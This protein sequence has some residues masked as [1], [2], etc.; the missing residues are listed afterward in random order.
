MKNNYELKKRIHLM[1]EIRGFDVLLMVAFHWF[2][3]LGYLLEVPLGVTLFNFFRPAEP[4]FAGLFIVICGISCHLSRSNLKRGLLLAG[5]AVGLSAVMY[6]FMPEQMIWFG[7]LHF[8]ALAILVFVPLRRL[9][10]RIPPAAGIAVC[11]VL[12]LLTWNLI[13]NTC[14]IGPGG[15]LAAPLP[16]WMKAQVWL[17]PLGLGRGP[18]DA[19]D[20]FPFFPWIFIFFIG[21][22]IGVWAKAGSFPDFAYRRRV[23]FLSFVGRHALPIYLVHQPVFYGIGMGV[24]WLIGR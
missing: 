13:G 19:A 12:A 5:V 1:D 22:F 21:C 10:E 3:V 18:G 24:K 23:P 15:A 11:L 9:V 7:I 4:F 16:D 8:L 2:Y 14:R 17:Y 20:Y 6:L